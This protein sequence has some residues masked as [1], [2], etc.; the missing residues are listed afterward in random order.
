[1]LPACPGAAQHPAGV[2]SQHWVEM[3][4]LFASVSSIAMASCGSSKTEG[5]WLGFATKDFGM[6][7]QG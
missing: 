1:M 3:F 5:G 6:A 7:T 4:I 2:R